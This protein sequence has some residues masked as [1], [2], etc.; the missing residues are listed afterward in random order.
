ML[1]FYNGSQDKENG[2]QLKYLVEVP[3]V[4]SVTDSSKTLLEEAKKWEEVDKASVPCSL[5][6]LMEVNRQFREDSYAL[7][8]R[9][10]EKI[11]QAAA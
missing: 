11:I 2:F 1:G 4:R 8:R 6:T 7:T 10:L 3:E 5:Y 9:Q